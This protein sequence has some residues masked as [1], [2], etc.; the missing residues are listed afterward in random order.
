L[1]KTYH[2]IQ[3]HILDAQVLAARPEPLLDA[4]VPRVV[5]LGRD[6]DLLTRHARVLDPLPDLALVAVR[7]RCVNVAVANF[8]SGLHCG[9]DG[10]RGRLPGACFCQWGISAV[11]GAIPRPIAGISAPVLSLNFWDVWFSVEAILAAKDEK[12]IRGIGGFEDRRR[13]GLWERGSG[14]R[15]MDGLSKIFRT[16]F[17]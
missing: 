6:P 3:I 1:P 4:L 17:L 16:E 15:S 13:S 12:R 5:Q 14:R 2:Q 10:A 8:E 7:E 11:G 9:A